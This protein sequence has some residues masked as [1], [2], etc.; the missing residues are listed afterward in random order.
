MSTHEPTK[1]VYLI[2]RSDWGEKWD[3]TPFVRLAQQFCEYLEQNG[4][5]A[6]TELDI[7][8]QKVASNFDRNSDNLY[9]F[10]KKDS[11]CKTDR[12]RTAPTH[13]SA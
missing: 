3:G 2:T 4:E 10:C 1:V 6:E 7:L 13:I 12:L 8:F 9:G 11:V 5:R